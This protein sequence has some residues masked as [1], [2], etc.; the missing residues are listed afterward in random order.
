MR[1]LITGGA[2][3]I[4]SQMTLLCEDNNMEVFVFDNLSRGKNELIV[5]KDRFFLG[6]LANTREIENC[7]KES[8]PDVVMHFAAFAYVGESVENPNIYYS[9][10]LIGTFNLIESM[11]K[12]GF[13]KLVFSSTCATYG[14]PDQFPISERTSQLP[15]NPYG[16]TKLYIENMLSDYFTAYDF[17]S[18]SFRYF[19]RCV[20][21]IIS[22]EI[23]LF[24][25][26]LIDSFRYN[27]FRSRSTLESVVR[28]LS[29]SQ[30]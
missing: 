13:T 12:L 21:V 26:A 20:I 22:F 10:N 6:D 8:N 11:R 2:G 3:Y 23:L 24:D 28:L 14:V 5:N 19:D 17:S 4:G 25:Q 9:N 18:I 7:L 27:F 16:K 1:I 30:L 15:I 29:I